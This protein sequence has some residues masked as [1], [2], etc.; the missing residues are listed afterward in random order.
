MA[1][2]RSR[3]PPRTASMLAGAALVLAACT[4]A[5][6]PP[7]PTES[8]LRYNS[9]D[10]E[11]FRD[12]FGGRLGEQRRV[13]LEG[14]LFLPGGRGPFP[15][16]VWQHGSDALGSASA[17]QWTGRLRDALAAR[18]IGLFVA[19]SHTGRGI[20][21]TMAD[22][23]QLSAASRAV[24][25][26]RAL[27]ALARDRRI[28]AARIGIAGWGSGGNAAIRASHERY[29]AAVLPGGPRYAAH[30]ALYPYCGYRFQR[31]RPAG[32]PLLFLLGGADNYTKAEPCEGLAGEM[33]KAGARVQIV[34]YPGAHHGFAGALPLRRN[35][36][37]W[38]FND[39]GII[40]LGTDG[41]AR[42]GEFGVSNGLTYRQF[43]T[44][45]VRSGCAKQGVNIGRDEA[46]GTDAL[47][48]IT[49]FFAGAFGK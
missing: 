48:R 26:L 31:Y 17:V 49:A 29:A 10:I 1:A 32:A 18:G 20:V 14:R 8:A 37:A 23:T 39:C 34:T 35:E 5:P 11:F 42:A 46:A 36:K 43:L 33:R 24:D 6:P 4:T 40:L 27:Q 15:V 22:Q 41:E 12:A 19:D 38:H 44:K 25:T 21:Y 7:P 2:S 16:V 9:S 28:D 3:M 45:A 13:R 30:V 47:R